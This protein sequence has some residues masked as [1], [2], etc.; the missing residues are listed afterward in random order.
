MPLISD[1]VAA[2][3]ALIPPSLGADWDNTGLQAGDPSAKAGAVMVALDATPEAV[4]EAAGAGAGLLVTHHPLFFRDIKSL[5]FSYGQGAAVMLASLCG[6]AIY[7]AHTSFDR[8]SPGV[9]DALAGAIG[10]RAIRPLEKMRGTP[11]AGF[12]RIGNLPRKM[13]ASDFAGLVKKALGADCVRIAGDPGKTVRRVAVCGGSGSDLIPLAAVSGADAFVTGDVKYHDALFARGMGLVLMDA[14]HYYTERC[15]L[16]LLADTV[17]KAFKKK[18]IK[19]KV[20]ISRTQG[21]PWAG[22]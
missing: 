3:E 1:M 22:I 2:V 12:G 21:E 8:V 4:D 15:A 14:G 17:A 16:P 7:S 18:G 6:V 11:G 13:K 10:L 19:A 5:D 20:I 9:S